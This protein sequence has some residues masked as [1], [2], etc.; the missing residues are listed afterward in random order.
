MNSQKLIIFNDCS[1]FVDVTDS[2]KELFSSGALDLY[3]IIISEQYESLI[4]SYESL[5]RILENGGIIGI[6]AWFLNLN[7]GIET[8]NEK[9]QIGLNENGLW[10]EN[11]KDGIWDFSGEGLNG[12]LSQNR[13]F[14]DENNLIQSTG[15][16]HNEQRVYAI[17]INNNQKHNLDLSDEEFIEIA[18]RE[19][20]VYTLKSF[21]NALNKQELSI[22]NN[23]VRF[24]TIKTYL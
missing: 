3:E 12:S 6:E 19:G 22:D 11:L 15:I 24:I 9:I 10:L 4:D 18:E 23:W 20:K 16:S 17:D 1:T 14:D 8:K 2:A 7:I 13:V 21:Q 5:E